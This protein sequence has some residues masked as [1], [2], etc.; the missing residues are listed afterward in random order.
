MTETFGGLT[1]QAGEETLCSG[2]DGR[3]LAAWVEAVKRL[4]SGGLL[5]NVGIKGEVFRLTDAGYSEA[6]RRAANRP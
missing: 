3:E 2:V 4:L 1:L 5:E 6:D